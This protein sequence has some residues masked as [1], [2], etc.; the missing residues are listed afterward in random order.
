[1]KVENCAVE[2]GDELLFQQFEN[3]VSHRNSD[4]E[5]NN[6]MRRDQVYREILRSFDELRIRSQGLEE[7]KSKILRSFFVSCNLLFSVNT[8]FFFVSIFSLFL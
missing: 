1:M 3:K 7:A 4:Y 8:I 2:E 6:Q 5:T